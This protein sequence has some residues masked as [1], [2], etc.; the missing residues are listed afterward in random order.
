MTTAKLEERKE[1][2]VLID[3]NRRPSAVDAVPTVLARQSQLF[4]LKQNPA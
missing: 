2:D 4:S 3:D 1:L